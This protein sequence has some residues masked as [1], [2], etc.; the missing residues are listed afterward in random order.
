MDGG[1]LVYLTEEAALAQLE[2]NRKLAFWWKGYLI[3]V[4]INTDKQAA[5]DAWRV[6]RRQQEDSP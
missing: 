2:E 3:T 5:E 6:I 1:S 4:Y